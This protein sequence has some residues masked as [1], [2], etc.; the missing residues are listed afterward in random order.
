MAVTFARFP[1]L[2]IMT[3]MRSVTTGATERDLLERAVALDQAALAEIHDRYYEPLLRYVA[4]RVPDRETAEDLTGDVFLRFLDALRGRRPPSTTLRG[5]LYGVAFHVVQDH[6]RKAYRA[7]VVALDERLAGPAATEPV[8]DA[9]VARHERAA[10]A[11]AMG[12]LTDEQQHV[13]ALRF[14]AAQPIQAVADAL[15]KTEGAIKQLQARAVAA[16]ARQ[17]THEGMGK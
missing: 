9:L 15:G 3:G 5:W 1:R 16:L 4:C 2:D 6:Y 17:M 10:L 7:D 8:D 11:Q 13:L 14:G 12:R